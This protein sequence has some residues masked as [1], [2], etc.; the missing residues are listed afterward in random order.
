MCGRRR[1]RRRRLNR[2]ATLGHQRRQC[3][4]HDAPHHRR[5]HSRAI[6]MVICISVSRRG[7]AEGSSSSMRPATH[8]SLKINR[9][10][11]TPGGA[12]AILFFSIFINRFSSGGVVLHST[13]LYLYI[14][15]HCIFMLLRRSWSNWEFLSR[16]R[17]RAVSAPSGAAAADSRAT[18]NQIPVQ[19]ASSARRDSLS[20]T[21]AQYVFAS[22]AWLIILAAQ[23]WIIQ[24]L[25]WKWKT[26]IYF[27]EPKEYAKSAGEKDLQISLLYNANFSFSWPCH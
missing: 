4:V 22:F 1:R 2:L 18:L 21:L 12:D 11:T 23:R 3:G 5:R 7:Y 15:E 16:Q 8:V 10:N 19:D 26:W 9:K 6:L 13:S 14:V 27:L 17:R 20:T 24:R 25:I